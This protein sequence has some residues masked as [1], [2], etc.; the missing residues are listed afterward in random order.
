MMFPTILEDG[1]V[2]ECLLKRYGC[3][4]WKRV[5]LAL[6]FW[7]ETRCVTTFLDERLLQRLVRPGLGR[8]ITPKVRYCLCS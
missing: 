7:I 2:F 4:C 1:Q 8:S 3:Y 5:H 6:V